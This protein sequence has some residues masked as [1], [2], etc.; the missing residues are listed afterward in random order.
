MD[1]FQ[2][3]LSGW[4]W[5]ENKLFEL[6]LAV[7]GEENPDR[8][9]VVAA[10]VGGKSAEE[11]EKHYGVLLED[12]KCIESGKLDHKFGEAQSFLPVECT[13]SAL[14]PSRLVTSLLHFTFVGSAIIES[15]HSGKFCTA[16]V[17]VVTIKIVPRFTFTLFHLPSI[18]LDARLVGHNLVSKGKNVSQ[19]RLCFLDRDAVQKEK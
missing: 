1:D 17:S 5:E 13:Q 3:G 18:I 8:W 2:T 6:A 14:P 10:M 19:S 16:W 4:S 15:K 7:V 9:K 12:L 11:V